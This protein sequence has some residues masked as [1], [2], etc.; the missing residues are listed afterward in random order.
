MGLKW[1]WYRPMKFHLRLEVK[2]DDEHILN[3][4]VIPMREHVVKVSLSEDEYQDL[5]DRAQTIGLSLSSYA[6]MSIITAIC[7]PTQLTPAGRPETGLERM[8]RL[9]AKAEEERKHNP[10][11]QPP[12]SCPSCGLE[13]D[14]LGRSVLLIKEDPNTWY[15]HACQAKGDW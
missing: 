9:K 12:A 10:P 2:S 5:K 15:C 7:K 14:D 13:H 1:A 8:T 11:K 6:R 4:E 3:W